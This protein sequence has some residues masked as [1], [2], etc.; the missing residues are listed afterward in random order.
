MVYFKIKIY[1]C[2]NW[3]TINEIFLKIDKE[4]NI[5]NVGFENAKDSKLIQDKLEKYDN[6]ILNA[7]VNYSLYTYNNCFSST[8]TK[9]TFNDFKIICYFW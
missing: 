7:I 9:I 6:Y 5:N 4:N 2:L 1:H 3:N 8:N